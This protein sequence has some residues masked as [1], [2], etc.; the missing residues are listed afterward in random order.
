MDAPGVRSSSWRKCPC[1]TPLEK[2]TRPLSTGSWPQMHL[3]NVD[4]PD[5]LRATSATRSPS[6]SPNVKSENSVRSPYVLVSPSTDSM[7]R[8]S[9]MR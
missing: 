4:L 6:C 2:T 7:F 5:P 3:S 8:R 9:A 1:L